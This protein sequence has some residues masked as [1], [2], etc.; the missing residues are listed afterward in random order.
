MEKDRAGRSVRRV[1]GGGTNGRR[2]A[3]QV[4]DDR[5]IRQSSVVRIDTKGGPLSMGVEE[6]KEVKDPLVF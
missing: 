4:G 5:C 3:I 6:E 2:I 1:W